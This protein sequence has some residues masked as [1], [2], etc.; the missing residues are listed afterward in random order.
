[1]IEPADAIERLGVLVLLLAMAGHAAALVRYTRAAVLSAMGVAAVL[2]IVPIAPHPALDYAFS[3]LGPL[4]SASLVL[5]LLTLPGPTYPGGR[6]PPVWRP[7]ILAVIVLVLSV[8]VYWAAVTGGGWDLYRLGY[9]SPQAAVPLLA[10]LLI[11]WRFKALAVTAWLLAG[12]LLFI[13]EAF[14]S[15]NLVDYMIDPFATVLSACLL[16]RV[17]VRAMA[18]RSRKRFGEEP[19]APPKPARMTGIVGRSERI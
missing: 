16:L 15:R 11:G 2:C 4:S 13:V 9:A 8:P 10:S 19:S 7:S 12:S 18:R 17:A 1:M 6:L 5:L 14:P 3:A